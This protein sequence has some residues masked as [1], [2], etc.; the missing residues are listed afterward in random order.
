MLRKLT[1]TDEPVRLPLLADSATA[2]AQFEAARI[3]VNKDLDAPKSENFA[4]EILRLIKAT[5]GDSQA[6]EVMKGLEL[7]AVSMIDK[8]IRPKQVGK[9]LANL[10]ETMQSH[11][12]REAV[13]YVRAQLAIQ[14]YRETS[15]VTDLLVQDP[16]GV[17]FVTVRALTADERRAAERKAGHKPRH[18]ALLASRAYDVLRRDSREGGDGNAAYAAHVA[19]MSVDDQS[20]LEDF[21]LWSIRVDREVVRSGV[22][23]IDGFEIE[24]NDNGY[25]VES[26]LSECV[27]GE[28]VISE[29]A[30]HIRNVATL[31]KSEKCLRSLESGT[32]ES[33][34]EGRV[35]VTAGS[36]LNASTAEDP[37]QS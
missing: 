30:R 13:A 24:R 37:H 11:D 9:A 16:R 33:E 27:E 21:E 34:D 4:E 3:E 8:N 26:F 15:D 35:L 17:S 10:R 18:G 28:E 12:S 31:G 25:D 20:A 32:A 29:A 14:R 2:D 23:S 1:H 5:V 6:L 7:A 19:K 22:I 36:A